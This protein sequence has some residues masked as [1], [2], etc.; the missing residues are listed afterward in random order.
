MSAER[1]VG[2]LAGHMRQVGDGLAWAKT[3]PPGGAR[4]SRWEQTIVELAESGDPRFLRLLAEHV[5]SGVIRSDRALAALK[6]AE[7]DAAVD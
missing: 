7:A 6:L 3:P 1:Q 4:G 5:E 2:A